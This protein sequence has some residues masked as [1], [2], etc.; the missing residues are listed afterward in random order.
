MTA[1][2]SPD[3]ALFAWLS[4]ELTPD[5]AGRVNAASGQEIEL[6]YHCHKCTA[7]CPVAEEMTFGPDHVLRL[8]QLGER[9][10]LLESSDIWLCAGCE[11]CATRC[12]NAID[13]ARVMDVLRH[14]ALAE[15][16][17]TGE[18]DA[19]KFHR[20]FLLVV[21]AFG[22]MH[23]AALLAAYKVW[24]GHLLADMD[25]GAVMLAKGKLPVLPKRIKGIAQVRRA[26]R[27]PERE[28]GELTRSE[29]RPRP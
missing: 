11:T 7:G 3:D 9:K 4:P 10:R 21:R 22:R 17:Q 25:S 1:W 12:P 27:E 13:I 23:E 18:P 6:C 2:F 26:F 28:P 29:G 19:V 8:V 24:S 5:L 14:M 16:G 20:L 15:A